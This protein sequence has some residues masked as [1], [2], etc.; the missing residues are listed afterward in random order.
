[1]E[2]LLSVAEKIIDSSVPQNIAIK[3]YEL[4]RT[5]MLKADSAY[6]REKTRSEAIDFKHHK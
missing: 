2:Y 5:L 3:Y 4:K 6:V 1:M